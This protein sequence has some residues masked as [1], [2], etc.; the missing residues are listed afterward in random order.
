MIKC[1]TLPARR[2]VG[3]GGDS[4]PLTPDCTSNLFLMIEIFQK[5]CCLI[6]LMC[7]TFFSLKGQS[8]YFQQDVHFEIDVRLDDVH[9][10]LHGY[11]TLTYTNNAPASLTEIV[12]HLWPNAYRDQSTAYAQQML[13]LGYTEFYFG[14]P[15]T[16]GYID[17]LDFKVDGVTASW[18]ADPQHPD[19]A[20]LKL[21]QA[22]AP[23][24]SIR[25]ETPFRVKLPL[26]YSRLGTPFSILSNMSM[27]SKARCL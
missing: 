7:W 21:P 24:A 25:I 18:Q 12:F 13:K 27:V 1:G 2:N 10:F 17:S 8:S 23:G 22:L 5:R 14:D 3:T 19:I 4:R 26:T 6:F 11:E 9:H 20:R 16:M 15:E